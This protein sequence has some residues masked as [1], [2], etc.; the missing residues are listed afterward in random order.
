[1]DFYAGD[2]AADTA[3]GNFNPHVVT[4]HTGEVI[5]D[6]CE[7][8]YLVISYYSFLLGILSIY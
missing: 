7:R 1:M 5:L 4:V 8:I 3:G 6:G 2:F